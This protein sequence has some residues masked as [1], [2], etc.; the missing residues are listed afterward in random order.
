[1]FEEL[2]RRW[3]IVAARG[4]VSVVFGI[5]ALAAPDQ[6]LAWLVKLFGFLALAD[7]IFSIGAGLSVSWLALF[8]EGC[9][10]IFVALV[11]LLAPTSFVEYWL[12]VN[13]AVY[14]VVTGALELR[15]A[16]GLKP[17]AR[18][19]MVRGD[20]ILGINGAISL[21]FGIALFAD[22]TVAP[23][24]L[25]LL[26]GGFAIASGLLLLAF[27]V[28]VKGWQAVLGPPAVVN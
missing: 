27:A 22:T 23:A 7:G 4:A 1:M 20:W 15:G 11:T 25:I 13:I 10:A 2:V 26:L 9:V 28:N 24:T 12:V 8:L 6:T 16:V 17:Q 3:W 14:M 18:G 5:A 19:T 21:L